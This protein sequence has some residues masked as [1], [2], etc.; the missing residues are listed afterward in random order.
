[1]VLC[2]VR[3]FVLSLAW[4]FLV[5]FP[6]K[7]VDADEHLDPHH[8]IIVRRAGRTNPDDHTSIVDEM[9]S[10]SEIDPTLLRYA[11]GVNEHESESC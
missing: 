7:S 8:R 2:F 9:Q 3:A 4:P 11:F 10:R 6:E 5:F 1:M